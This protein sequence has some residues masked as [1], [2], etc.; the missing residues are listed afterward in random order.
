MSQKTKGKPVRNSVVEMTELVLPHH[1]NQLGTIFGGQIMA[2]I[3]IAAAI[4]AGR[5]SRRTCVTASIDAMNFV[6]PVKLGHYVLIKA[7]VNYAGRT[8]MEIGVRLDSENPATGDKTHVA[9]AYLTFVALDH[10]GRPTETPPVIPET[11]TQKRRY[12]DAQKRR[13]MRLKTR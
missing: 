12:K 10:N 5:H 2:W 3:D 11:D 9:T 13:A 7:S 6:A 4:A 8:S 1:T